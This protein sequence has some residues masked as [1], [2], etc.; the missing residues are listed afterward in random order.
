M[1]NQISFPNLGISLSINRVAFEIFGVAVYWYGL[2][3]AL[4]LTLAM[5][6]GYHESKR[7]KLE[8]DDFLNMILIAVP[9]AILC[10]RAYYVIFSWEMYRDDWV[11]VFDIRSGGIAIYG[12]VIGAGLTVFGYCRAKKISAPKVLDILA[13][14]LLIGQCIGRWGNFV[15]GEAFGASCDLPW[16]MTIQQGG[17]M[18]ADSVHP[19]FFYESL[20]NGI[21]IAVLLLYKKMKEFDGELFCAYLSWYGLGRVW[22]EGLRADSLYIGDV[23]VSQILAG[24][25]AIV[26]IVIVIRMRLGGAKIETEERTNRNMYLIVGLGNPGREYV[27]TRHNMGFEAV[28]ALC[29]KFDI[30]M[31]KEKFRAVYGEGRIGTEKVLVI[32]PQTYMNLSG[33]AVREFRDWYKIEED[34]I[35]VLYDDLSLPVGKLRIREKGSAGGHNGIKNIIYQLG[36]D[37]FPRIKIGIGAPE[38][39]DYD[40]KDYVLGKFSEEEVKI[41]IQ[42]VVRAVSAVEEIMVH[43]PKSAM[44]LYNG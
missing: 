30:S 44:N 33:E 43:D 39:P 37:E 34:H 8:T 16:A 10:A 3:I 17:R 40:T 11:S 7:V 41:L 1:V 31:K 15:N 35:I 23:R 5:V 19:T 25:T 27:G 14:G 4:G 21:G 32:K 26:G 42:T 18:V 9:V 38:H 6:Y 13:V 20:W 29:S 36:T 24:L 28:D 22:I 2:L 12:G